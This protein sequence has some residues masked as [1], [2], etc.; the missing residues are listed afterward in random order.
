MSVTPVVVEE[1]GTE[2]SGGVIADPV[3]SAAAEWDRAANG[4]VEG[5]ITEVRKDWGG[6][7]GAEGGGAHGGPGRG[8]GRGGGRIG[9]K[10]RRFLGG[11]SSVMGGDDSEGLG[12]PGEGILLEDR[13]V[14]GKEA[15]NRVL[16]DE[17]RLGGELRCV[18]SGH[19]TGDY[20]P[21]EEVS[22]TKL[23]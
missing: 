20:V 5:V 23:R 3:S 17:G 21:F 10:G 19:G 7:R 22:G 1:G 14:Q 13:G 2:A 4:R 9:R 16:G 12:I 6:A 18:S 11:R 8:T 15:G